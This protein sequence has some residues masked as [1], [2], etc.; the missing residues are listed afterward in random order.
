M[1]KNT[2]TVLVFFLRHAG[3]SRRNGADLWSVGSR[4]GSSKYKDESTSLLN[5]SIVLSVDS[6]VETS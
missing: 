4:F 1:R 3:P 5:E 6:E 2:R